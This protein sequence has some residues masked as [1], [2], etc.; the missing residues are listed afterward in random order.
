[1]GFLHARERSNP[2]SL[3]SCGL[4]VVEDSFLDDQPLVCGNSFIIPHCARERSFLSAVALDVHE[5]AAIAELADELLRRSNERSAGVVSFV[6]HR[7]IE[8]G[9]MS[10]GFV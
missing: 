9:G 3:F 7:S 2:R 10:D 6:S 1:M 5:V 4:I 8:L